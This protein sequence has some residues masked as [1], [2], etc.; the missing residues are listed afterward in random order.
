MPQTQFPRSIDAFVNVRMGSMERP[1][2][3][4]RVAEDYFKR[5][6]QIFKDIEVEQ[7]VDEMDRIGVERSILST[8]VVKP[9]SHTLSFV[10]KHPDRFVLSGRLIPERACQRLGLCR[11][12]S[13]INQWRWP[14]HSR[15]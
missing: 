14:G 10:E 9:C 3:L 8:P 11:R 13:R 12:S 6:E 15:S 7:L 4:V 2:W 5:S 1:S